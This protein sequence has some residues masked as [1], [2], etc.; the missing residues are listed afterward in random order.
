[1]IQLLIYY[2]PNLMIF[3]SYTSKGAELMNI[4]MKQSEYS[5]CGARETNVIEEKIRYLAVPGS[6][7][8]TSLS[9]MEYALNVFPLMWGPGVV[10]TKLGSCATNNK[11]LG[12]INCS[13]CLSISSASKSSPYVRNTYVKM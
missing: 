5:A 3:S 13:P 7:T 4:E 1:M 10:L 9:P 12:I 6:K 8:S 11:P 2:N